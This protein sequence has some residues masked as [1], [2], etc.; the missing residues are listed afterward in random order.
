MSEFIQNEALLLT[1]LEV[2]VPLRL[3]EMVESSGG[4]LNWNRDVVPRTQELATVI[5][6]KGDVILFRSKKKGESAKAWASLVEALALL[7]L[8]PGGV[9]FR[10]LHWRLTSS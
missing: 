5:G 4:H 3:L 10:G 8:A 9:K 7:S 6:E 1:S 2:A